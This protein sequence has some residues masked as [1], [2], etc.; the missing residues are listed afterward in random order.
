MS[1]APQA[2]LRTKVLTA[3]PAELRL[4]LL[5]GAIRF[6]EQ[7]KGG[8]ETRDLERALDGTTKCQAILTELMCSL[9]P[10][11]N[12]DLCDKLSA[13]YTY[14]YKRL[15]E[16]SLSKDAE[17]VAEVIGLLQYDRETWSMLM[18]E[19]VANGGGAP[20]TPDSTGAAPLAPSSQADP[21]ANRRLSVRG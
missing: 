15:V 20:Q 9:R 3:S 7:T 8:Y 12:P 2:Y 13:L 16:A 10:E 19:L 18:K 4:L 6:A 1:A 5:D 17:I 14:M 21:T 11:H